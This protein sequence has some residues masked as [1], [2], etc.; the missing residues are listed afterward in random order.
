[1]AL[2]SRVQNRFTGTPLRNNQES[3]KRVWHLQYA[4]F[5]LH[6]LYKWCLYRPLYP[7]S[8]VCLAILLSAI[9]Y[10]STYEGVSKSFR[11]GRLVRELQMVQLFA[12]KCSCISILWVSRVS[13]A[14]IT[15][16]VASQR[17]FMFVSVYFIMAQFGKLLDIPST[18][19]LQWICSCTYQYLQLFILLSTW[20]SSLFPVLFLWRPVYI[21]SS[22]IYHFN[23]PSPV[24]SSHSVFYFQRLSNLPTGEWHEYT[25]IGPKA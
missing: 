18:C 17:V 15:L 19:H 8:G 21:Q 14:I 24:L 16:C 25:L 12:T 4:S 7:L 6:G 11:T 13:F 23:R 9:M 5:C 10:V 2:L 3:T 20:S 22:H 1:M